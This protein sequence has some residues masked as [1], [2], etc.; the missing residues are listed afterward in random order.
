MFYLL[1]IL[2]LRIPDPHLNQ[3]YTQ[4]LI[5][6]GNGHAYKGCPRSQRDRSVNTGG[7]GGDH[8]DPLELEF[9]AV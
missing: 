9:R 8:G 2:F 3:A 6:G 1:V 4:I 7:G 5:L